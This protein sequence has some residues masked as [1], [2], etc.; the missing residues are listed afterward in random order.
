MGVVVGEGV[1]VGICTVEV[2]FWVGAVCTGVAALAQPATHELIHSK[3][4]ANSDI[5]FMTKTY[6]EISYSPL[7]DI[8]LTCAEFWHSTLKRSCSNVG[9]SMREYRPITI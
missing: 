1:R 4:N 7:D 3:L 6:K 2:G 9:A 8:A 5:L